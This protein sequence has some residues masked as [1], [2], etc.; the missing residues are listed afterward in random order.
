MM[1]AQTNS[2]IL[3]LY[4]KRLEESLIEAQIWNVQIPL[5]RLIDYN[6]ELLADN[7]LKAISI[8][9]EMRKKSKKIFQSIQDRNEKFALC[10]IMQFNSDYKI[11][12]VKK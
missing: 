5:Q 4:E 10:R 1:T 7:I 6:K 9:D 2:L 11:Q 8:D 12:S 3:L